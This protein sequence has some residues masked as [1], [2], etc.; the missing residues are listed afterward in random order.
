MACSARAPLVLVVDDDV[1]TTLLIQGTLSSRGFQV[2]CA[3]DVAGATT[4]IEERHPDLILLDVNLP[5]GNGLDLCRKLKAEPG[6][7]QTPVLFISANEE[8]PAKIKGFNAGAADYISKPFA[9]EEV[10]ARVSTHL[11]LKQAYEALAEFHAARI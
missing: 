11:R 10:V 5:D 6:T 4:V 3:F 9:G 8:L 1:A 2:V 7:A